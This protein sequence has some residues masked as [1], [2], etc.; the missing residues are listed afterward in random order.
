MGAIKQ[1]SELIKILLVACDQSYWGGP[2]TNTPDVKNG[3]IPLGTP[4]GPYSDTAQAGDSLSDMPVGWQGLPFTE[5]IVAKRYDDPATGF[6]ATLYRKQNADGSGDYIVAMQGT[7]GINLQDWG[8]NL[9]YGRD[10]WTSTRS[11]GGQELLS[12]LLQLRDTNQI[13]FTGQSLGGA[14]AEYALYEYAINKT[15]FSASQVTLTTFNGLGSIDGL[16]QAF[17]DSFNASLVRDVDTAHFWIRNDI[18]NRLGGGHLNGAG[19]EY[20]L[21]FWRTD[22]QGRVERRT[23][24]TPIALDFSSAHRV[25]KG[26]YSGFNRAQLNRQNGDG[27]DPL[28][29]DF[30]EAIPSAISSL[31]LSELARTGTYFA[32]LTNQDDALSSRA[33]AFGRLMA[34]LTISMG[35]GDENELRILVDAFADSSYEAGEFDKSVR[36]LISRNAPTFLRTLSLSPSGLAVAVAGQ[37]LALFVEGSGK[38][39][40]VELPDGLAE[41]SLQLVAGANVPNGL[42]AFDPVKALQET[43]AILSRVP[44]AKKA[45][46]LYVGIA[47]TSVALLMLT[48]S[49][50]QGAVATLFARARDITA[51]DISDATETILRESSRALAAAYGAT[52][53][54]FAKGLIDIS[55]AL[56]STAIDVAREATVLAID[57][58]RFV[59][60][61]EQGVE[62]SVA[63]VAKGIANAYDGLVVKFADAFEFGGNVT[64]ATLDNIIKGL[65]AGEQTASDAVRSAL[66]GAAAIL[67]NAAEYPVL[68]RLALKDGN[69]FDDPTFDP[70]TAP[71][72]SGALAEG[73]A[74]TYG[75]SLPY[76]AAEGG[77]RIKVQLQGEGV[78]K[79]SIV[80]DGMSVPSANGAFYL[81]I[82]QG[83]R[84]ASF[85]LVAADDVGGSAGVS[86]SV[87]LVDANGVATHQTHLEANV[88]LDHE[89]QTFSTVFDAATATDFASADRINGYFTQGGTQ[90]D[91]TVYRT[92]LVG[93]TRGDLFIGDHASESLVAGGGNDFV[94]EGEASTGVY[95][96]GDAI[97]AGAGNDLVSGWLAAHISAGDGDDFVNASDLIRLQASRIGTSGSQVLPELPAEIYAD[98]ANFIRIRP[99]DAPAFN[100]LIGSLDFSY[101]RDFG[102]DNVGNPI[103]GV[104]AKM[105]VVDAGGS[106]EIRRTATGGAAF[107]FTTFNGV[108]NITYLGADAPLTYGI[109]FESTGDLH[110]TQEVEI[111]G[112]GGNDLLYGAGG[113]DYVRG[114]A[115]GDRIAGFGGADTL[116]G[117]D[118]DDLIVAGAGDDYVDAGAGNDQVWGEDGYDWLTG[119]AGSDVLY[120]DADSTP[121]NLQGDD[122]LDG[123]AGDDQL[124]G[125]GGADELFGG[126]GNDVLDG[127]EGDDDLDGESGSDRLAGG[128]G[129]DELFG[130]DGADVLTG[131]DGD[132]DLDGEAGDDQLAGGAGDDW[133]EGESGSDVL[134]GGD[135]NDTLY[136]GD[137]H[138]DLQGG[139]GNDWLAGGPGDNRFSGGAGDDVYVLEFG[140]DLGV[141]D[142]PLGAN[143]IAFGEGIVRGE[144]G[145]AYADPARG[146]QDLLLTYGDSSR[147]WLRAG[148]L[149]QSL[150][151]ADG[152]SIGLDDLLATNLAADYVPRASLFIGTS[153]NDALLDTSG[154]NVIAHGLDGND[155]L[156]TGAGDDVLDGGPGFDTLAGGAGNDTYVYDTVDV[157]ADT[158][159]VNRVVFGPGIDPENLRT[160][161]FVVSGQPRLLVAHPGET[162]QGLELR[163]IALNSTNFEYV[164]ADGRVLSQSEFLQASYGGAQNLTGG[165]ADDTLTGFAGR[166]TLFGGAG[167]DTLIGNAGDDNLNGYIGDDTLLGGPGN[168]SLFGGPGDDVLSG[169]AGDDSLVG[170]EGADTY[171]F[172]YGDGRDIVSDRGSDGAVDTLRMAD[173]ITPAEVSITREPNSD[174]SVALHGTDDKLTLQGWYADATSRVERIAFADG[175]VLD[176]AQLAAFGVPPITGSGGADLLTGTSYG[177]TLQGLAGDDTLDGRLGDDVL[178]GGAGADSYVLGWGAG[179]DRVIEE[180]GEAGTVVLAPAMRLADIAA[181]RIGDDLFLH[182]L[183]TESGLV[184]EDYYSQAQDW[185]IRTADGASEPL[186]DFL[187]RPPATTGDPVLDLWE[188]RKTEF[189]SAFYGSRRGELLADG[190]VFYR[191]PAIGAQFGR[192]YFNGDIAGG[193]GPL[194]NL[195][196]NDYLFKLESSAS[197]SDAVSQFID[198]GRD[199]STF[200]MTPATYFDVR[201]DTPRVDSTTFYLGTKI[202]SDGIAHPLY[203]TST[204]TTLNGYAGDISVGV[205]QG[206][207][208]ADVMMAALTYAP[209]PS[210]VDGTLF[211]QTVVTTIAEATAGAS[212]NVIHVSG[213]GKVDAGGGDDL[214]DSVQGGYPNIA[215]TGNFL[216]GGRGNDRI[217]GS[218][219]RD[220]ILGGDGSDTLAG[221]TDDDTYYFM[222]SDTGSDLVNEATWYLWDTFDGKALYNADSGALSTDTVEF[223]PGIALEDLVLDYGTVTTRYW[224]SP[225][226]LKTYDTLDVSW[227]TGKTARIMLPDR[228]DPGVR[229]DLQNYPGSSW[230]VEDFRFADGT[231]LTMQ[232]MARRV[233]HRLMNGTSGDDFLYGTVV[234]DFISAGDGNDLLDAGPGDDFLVGW[235]GFD[236]YVFRRGDGAD[237]VLD[238][239]GGNIAIRGGVAAADLAVTRDGYSNLYVVI[240]GTED[241][242]ELL[243]WYAGANGYSLQLPG[244]EAWSAA[245]LE[246]MVTRLPA[247]RLGDVLLGSD[248][249]DV[250][251]GL[252]GDDHLFGLAGNDILVGGDGADEVQDGPGNNLLEG[253]AGDDQIFEQ[254]HSLVIGGAGDDYV[255]NSGD[256]AVVAFN[257]GDGNDTIYVGGSLTLSLGAGIDAAALTLRQAGPD[258]LLSIGESDSILLT[259]WSGVQ[260]LAWPELRLQLVQAGEVAT[261]DL[262]ALIA[263]LDARAAGDPSVVLP[264]APILAEHAVSLSTSEAI[265][266]AIAYRYAIRGSTD[267]L[268]AAQEQAVLADAAFGTAAQSIVP[269]AVNRPPALSHALAEQV[270]LE[271][272][273]FTFILPDGAFVDPDAGDALTYSASLSSGAALPAWLGFD[274]STVTFSGTPAQADVGSLDIRLTATDRAGLSADG[275]FHLAILNTNDA[276]ETTDDLVQVGEDAVLAASGNVLANDSDV[277]AGTLLTVADPGSV[278]GAY[279]VLDL[280]ADGHFTYS[281]NNDSAQV[282]ALTGGQLA[283]DDFPYAAWDGIAGTPGVLRVAVTG[284]NDAPVANHLLADVSA[285]EDEPFA[286]SLP[287]AAFADADEG[288]VLAYSASRADGSALPAWLGF[289]PGTLSFSGTPGND[290]VGSQALRLTA[291]DR[292]GASSSDEFV[293][294][295]ENVND[296]PTVLQDIA[297]QYVEA[298]TAFSFTVPAET[299][300]DIDA[301]DALA[302]SAAAMG[303]GAFPAWLRFDP[304]TSTLSGVPGVQDIGVT[305]IEVRATDTAGAAAAADFA[306]VVTASAGSKVAGDSG[307]DVIYGS[308]GNETLSA[309]AGDD[310]LFGAAGND[311]LKGGQGNDVLQ[312]GDGSDVLHGGTGQSVLDGGAGDDVIF[313]GAGNSFISGGWGN[314]TIRFG[315]GSDIL[316]FNRGDGR[317]TVIGGGDGGNTLSLGGGIRYSDLSFAKA[318]NDLVVNTGSDDNILFKDWYAGSKSILNLQIVLD[319]TEEFDAASADPLRNRRVE[320]FDFGGLVDAFDQARLQS[321]GLTSWAL[322]NALLQYHLAGSDDEA[323]GG[324][325]AY[326]YARRGA[327]TGISLQAAQE[328]I[329]APGFGSDAQRLQAFTGLQDGLVKLG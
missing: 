57:A 238:N 243:N 140:E 167:N 271:D 145:A 114:G 174:L 97:D 168:D 37:A 33:E 164:F 24:S 306:L 49:I 175:T 67:K 314:D 103:R 228:L 63:E 31:Q 113:E 202:G 240:K 188:A 263:D 328:I 12:D 296:A 170:S 327:L 45:V 88:T 7:R 173:G 178:I 288:D 201:W 43:N 47:S 186:A 254:G 312:G 317:D 209:L 324:D 106:T 261:Y 76:E 192:N 109:A 322:T 172:G 253:G 90:N 213:W 89:D 177:D 309:G 182:T 183:R 30:I 20:A 72:T 8:G 194:P 11:G 141:I 135:G 133:L 323:I 210:A 252:A 260:P 184:L 292:V 60:L 92:R 70:Q 281:L 9:I 176:E 44:G 258:L 179:K 59:D 241:R 313:D 196:S 108:A 77:Q 235:T 274:A 311:V 315:A 127:A 290:D 255:E 221:W 249:D 232:E 278:T 146:P 234:R 111:D 53:D 237:V 169:G 18:V 27:R 99:D 279:G 217:T 199:S 251:D 264:L 203:Q 215:G 320:T 230:G 191:D 105:G 286:V 40:K 226:L 273:S 125:N 291:T 142:D 239:D 42:L 256:G 130:G 87:T 75:F 303:G 297:D 131:D 14:L 50:G 211:S 212:N 143:S 81:L 160:S 65:E 208:P 10:K 68:R 325:L 157:V 85:A 298:G 219:R 267:G 144:V 119:G 304:R 41:R 55:M 268:E 118:G 318:G 282:Q 171:L 316:A 79:L 15:D 124:F 19:N 165:A 163:G 231:V 98:L 93:T 287:A 116:E 285:T 147:V 56:V 91:P 259:D 275:A 2:R 35:F 25:E 110:S 138:D 4:L 319:A 96:G 284:Q 162:G 13:H 244:G 276:P 270:A 242:I 154:A 180:A 326:W 236:T 61:V 84:E 80:S 137:G 266:G 23:D 197:S 150:Q 321:P 69:P 148:T 104:S 166:D 200:T 307:D 216:Y 71:T 294:T 310:A 112:G 187:A 152:T 153:G 305:G 73:Q 101:A 223:G 158:Q 300:G 277:D 132:D 22:A 126:D 36:N 34:A 190:T 283:F 32:W 74:E 1:P 51:D 301:G 128:V 159:G 262:D 248:G 115:G 222:A 48:A 52:S 120:G 26:F 299:F 46:A 102:D 86:I 66:G 82:P 58:K 245:T 151:F 189:K 54:A 129:N 233:A 3:P 39:D 94:V 107:E 272:T 308:T 214:I 21:N 136:G 207:G 181:A 205:S 122:Y 204:G 139:E 295:V 78:G 17:R 206:A 83:R 134:V 250:I 6:G 95:A 265:G 195:S 198:L 293:L 155:A 29:T 329:G 224:F 257:A 193:T 289:D 38:T 185:R 64:R 218:G 123:G 5:W 247:T 280:S 117:D 227:G 161:S 100:P 28:P 62:T 16:K 269:I 156:T 149:V 220:L 246:A 225:S 229:S 302:V 121:L